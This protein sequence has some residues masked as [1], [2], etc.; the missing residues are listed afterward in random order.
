LNP[1]QTLKGDYFFHHDRLVFVNRASEDFE[2]QVH[3]HDFFEFAYVAEGTGFHHVDGQV[4]P[5]HK[6]QICFIPVGIPH[7]FRPASTDVARHPL[8]VYNCILSPKLLDKLERFVADPEL[9][10]FIGEMR[11][12]S[13]PYFHLPDADDAI[14]RL[15]LAM[16]REFTLPREAASDYLDTL[17]IQLLIVVRRLQNRS[18][19][20]TARKFT[21]FDHLLS[22]IEQHLDEPLSLHR[23]ATISRWS[24]R[25]LQRLF[26][27]HAEQ[28]FNDHLQ[29]MRIQKSCELLRSTSIKIGSIAGMVGYRDN[30]SFLSVFKR[31]VGTTPSEYRKTFTE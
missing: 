1:M 16:H 6:G 29:A 25:H 11:E 20:S 27:R 19:S 31:I 14:E 30:A 18:P 17:L 28:S 26:R 2:A 9:K 8:T 15:M 5:I 3:D 24:E 13:V 21:Q 10:R 22:Y 4:H 23:L 7:V 12:E